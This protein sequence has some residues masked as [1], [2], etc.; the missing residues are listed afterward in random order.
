MRPVAARKIYSTFLVTR[1][2]FPAMK[3]DLYETDYYG[4]SNQQAALLRAGKLSEADIE[5]IAE[6]IESMGKGEKRELVSRLRVLMLHLLKWQFQP[7]FRGS[8]W[9][10]TIKTQRLDIAR[11]MKI[12]PSLKSQIADSV[13]WAYEGA[14]L[15]ASAH[16]GLPGKVFPQIC[17]WTFA[18][19]TDPD[20]WPE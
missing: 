19:M 7:A 15:D 13:E 18:E 6:E 3:T 14:Q 1:C 4:W 12:N 20:F 5:N 10:I 2:I 17:P 9:Q 8:S 16:T 11:H